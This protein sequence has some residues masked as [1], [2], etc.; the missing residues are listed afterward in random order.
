MPRKARGCTTFCVLRREKRWSVPCAATRRADQA[1][2]CGTEG[3]LV[4]HSAY[5]RLIYSTAGRVLRYRGQHFST[6]GR[7]PRYR[8]Q[9]FSTAGRVLRYR[10]PYFSAGSCADWY[11]G[12]VFPAAGLALRY[13]GRVFPAAGLARRYTGQ[14]FPANTIAVIPTK[15]RPP[16]GRGTRRA[17]I[18]RRESK[19][20]T[21]AEKR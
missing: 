12:Q 4:R 7:S 1:A 5:T 20:P 21:D 14:V 6:A 11:T 13:T 19:R 18:G 16:R 2:E 8:G 10:G 17:R 15:M 3:C 9:H